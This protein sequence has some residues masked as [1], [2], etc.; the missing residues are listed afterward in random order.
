MTTFPC[1]GSSLCLLQQGKPHGSSLFEICLAAGASQ[2]P[3]TGDIAGA[4]GHTHGA[5]GIEQVKGVRTLQAIFI[6]WQDQESRNNPLG[7]RMG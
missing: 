2:V 6:S 4:L 5:T 3:H 1:E 7:W